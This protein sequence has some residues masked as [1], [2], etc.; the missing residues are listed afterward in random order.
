MFSEAVNLPGFHCFLKKC[1]SIKDKLSPFWAKAGRGQ[2]ASV[3]GAAAPSF[4][5]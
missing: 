3:P 2:L 4:S 5:Y 1:P